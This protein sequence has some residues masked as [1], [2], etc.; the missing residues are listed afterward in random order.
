MSM[1]ENSIKEET[2]QKLYKRLVKHYLAD[3]VHKENRDA[4]LTAAA[5]HKTTKILVTGN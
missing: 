3:E 1:E 4:I 2:K 5:Y